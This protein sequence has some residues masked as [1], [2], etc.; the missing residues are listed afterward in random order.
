MKPGHD[1]F[2]PGSTAAERSASDRHR[3]EGTFRRLAVHGPE[4]RHG[5]GDSEAGYRGL[6]VARRLR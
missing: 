2:T 5:R 3:P 4:R 6:K 1:A